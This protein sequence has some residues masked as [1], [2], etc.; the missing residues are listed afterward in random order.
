MTDRCD[1]EIRRQFDQIVIA[2][3][4][5]GFYDYKV[6]GKAVLPKSYENSPQKTRPI[7]LSGY[8]LQAVS[9]LALIAAIVKNL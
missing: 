2:E 9:L 6:D 8:V 3:K 4:G 7:I 1:K 5:M